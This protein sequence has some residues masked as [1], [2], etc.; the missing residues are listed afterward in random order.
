MNKRI[1]FL[2]SIVICLGMIISLEAN[3]TLKP[4]EGNSSEEKFNRQISQKPE[5]YF[6][7]KA[8]KTTTIW[9]LN[10][11]FELLR[12]KPKTLVQKDTLTI[13][14]IFVNQNGSPREGMTVQLFLINDQGTACPY[15]YGADMETGVLQSLNP[16]SKSDS[17][18]HFSIR[19]G[20]LWKIANFFVIGMTAKSTGGGMAETTIMGSV[21]DELKNFISGLNESEA[22]YETFGII[23]VMEGELLMK[24]PLDVVHNKIDLGK[25]TVTFKDKE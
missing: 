3:F 13:E 12:P 4:Y 14:G 16:E 21:D 9:P 25:I 6:G 24:I 15:F 5:K 2:T 17:N 23:P 1:C 10:E 22:D 7:N 8:I 18:G 20:P 11:F 19:T